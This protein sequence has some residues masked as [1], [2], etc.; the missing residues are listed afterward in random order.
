MKKKITLFL[1]LATAVVGRAQTTTELLPVGTEAPDFQITNDKTGEKMFRL[2]DWKTKTDADGK[3][4]PGV[5]T[6]LDFWASW[7]PDC[8]KDMPKVKEISKKYL[9]KI[10]LVGISF[11][12]DKEKMN[13]YLNSNHYDQW[14][15]Y[16]EGKK[17]K[18]TQI[19]KDYHISW[20]PTSYLIDPEGKVY[21]ST[22]KAEEMMQK[23]DSLNNLGKLTAFIEMPHY[24][25]GKAVLMKQ[26]SVNTKFPKLCQKYKAAAKVKVE[27]IVEKDGNVSDVGIQSYQ[28]LDNPNGKDFNK[29]SGAEQNQV[30]S[31]IRTLFEQEGIRVVSTLGKW[32]P[33]K[34]RGETTRVHYTVPIVFRLY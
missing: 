28:V 29:L 34:I 14:M 11:D 19:S 25:G 12:T 18:E 26:L 27:F 15:Q 32:I 24:P 30:R 1:L 16:C 10:Q 7:C 6:V 3:V 9:T 4:V 17:W 31:Q 22:V 2:S 33:G 13:K 5:W 8:R 20:I 21:F 23:L